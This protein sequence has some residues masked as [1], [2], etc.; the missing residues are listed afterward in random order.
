MLN[1][2]QVAEG[3]WKVVKVK[4]KIFR[5]DYCLARISAKLVD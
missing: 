1:A 2:L 5:L 3:T 4:L